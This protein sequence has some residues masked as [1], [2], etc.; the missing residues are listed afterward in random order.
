MSQNP[1]ASPIESGSA[2]KANS[3]WIWIVALT[4]ALMVPIGCVC[5]GCLAFSYSGARDE[6]MFESQQQELDVAIEQAEAEAQRRLVDPQRSN[7]SLD[8]TD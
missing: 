6:A 4:C 5:S 2:S 3:S 7:N 1:Y 8:S